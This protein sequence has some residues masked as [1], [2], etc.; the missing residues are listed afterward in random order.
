MVI[1]RQQDTG[2]KANI[3]KEPRNQ[4]DPCS[5][6]LHPQHGRELPTDDVHW[7]LPVCTE[8]ATPRI[9]PILQMRKWRSLGG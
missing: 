4:L 5:Q 1:C 9:V 2:Y 8:G 3:L 7:L 6:H